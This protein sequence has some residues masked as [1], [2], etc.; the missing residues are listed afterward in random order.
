MVSNTFLLQKVRIVSQVFLTRS[1]LRSGN[2]SEVFIK[3]VRLM[4]KEAQI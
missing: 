4:K 3:I 1:V 2:F